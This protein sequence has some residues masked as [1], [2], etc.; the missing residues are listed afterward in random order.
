[1]YEVK[2]DLNIFPWHEIPFVQQWDFKKNL[3]VK[4]QSPIQQDVLRIIPLWLTLMS[5]FMIIS[6][7]CN[8]IICNFDEKGCNVYFFEQC[9]FSFVLKMCHEGINK[10]CTRGIG[11]WPRKT[12]HDTNRNLEST[13]AGSPS[14][15]TTFSTTHQKQ[16]LYTWYKWQ[17]KQKN[18]KK[19]HIPIDILVDWWDSR[20]QFVNAP[21]PEPFQIL[22]GMMDPLVDPEFKCPTKER[23]TKKEM[24]K[25]GSTG[26]YSIYT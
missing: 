9:L 16:R 13:K 6:M 3:K 25:D 21:I 11:F 22:Q 7:Y 4:I 19:C 15:T 10:K 23:E 12:E 5:L 8:Y 2:I 20:S 14:H 18:K 17:Q 24:T 1:M 26:D